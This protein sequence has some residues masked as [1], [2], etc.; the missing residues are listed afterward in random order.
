MVVGM[1][2]TMTSNKNST[3][4]RCGVDATVSVPIEVYEALQGAADSAEAQGNIIDT[5]DQAVHK[6]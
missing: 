3:S 1:I 6:A 4:W 2:A 5:W